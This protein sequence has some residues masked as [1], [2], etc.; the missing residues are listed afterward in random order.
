VVVQLEVGVAEAKVGLG[1]FGLE[2]DGAPVGLQGF[3]PGGTARSA[4]P[5]PAT[6]L[7]IL[8]AAANAAW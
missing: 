5:R 3:I 2:P 1:I 6:S 8:G 4:S 7:I